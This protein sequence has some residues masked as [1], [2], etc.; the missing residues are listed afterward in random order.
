V[1]GEISRRTS[2]SAAGH[3]RDSE[4]VFH[5]QLVPGFFL[6]LKPGNFTLLKSIVIQLVTNLINYSCLMDMFFRYHFMAV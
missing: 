6:A 2:F 3:G 4:L 1:S 5:S